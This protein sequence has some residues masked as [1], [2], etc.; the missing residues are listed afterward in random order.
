MPCLNSFS[1][2]GHPPD[3]AV[4]TTVNPFAQ[5][6]KREQTTYMSIRPAVLEDAPPIA[7]LLHQLGYPDTEKAVRH[8]LQVLGSQTETVILVAQDDGRQLGGCIQVVIAN[9]LAEG[10]YGEIASLV[11]AEDE[12]GRGTGRRLVESAAAWLKEQGMA[13]M[14]V[15][16]NAIRE[17]AHR[18]YARLGFRV[19]KSQKIFDHDLSGSGIS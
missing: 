12:R 14:R 3:D 10:Q 13:R 8:R 7:A 1:N 4:D 17:D 6:A 2:R 16:C 5:P 15:R 18:F 19:T 11:V 9:R